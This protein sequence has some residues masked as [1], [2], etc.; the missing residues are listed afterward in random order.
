MHSPAGRHEY[1]TPEIHSLLK[2]Q[3]WMLLGLVGWLL[4]PGAAWAVDFD[5]DEPQT[6]SET[7]PTIVILPII[8]H[9]A[10]DPTHLREGF[11]DMLEA[12]VDQIG[13]FE[14]I[15]VSDPAKA[16]SRLSEALETARELDADFVLFGSFTQFGKGASLD[17]QMAA[18]DP[19]TGQ[20]PL[21]QIFVHSGS[22]GEII[23]DLDKLVGK[24][25]QYAI[26][27][28]DPEPAD[29]DIAEADDSTGV[30]ERLSE[31]GLLTQRVEALELVVSE[32]QAMLAD[33]MA[34]LEATE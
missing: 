9:S 27:D 5:E 10:A 26:E 16:T 2:R 31:I 15:N 22:I 14:I 24:L 7:L 18:T 13:R 8:V 21:R 6:P 33:R 30:E 3:S 20:E 25:G 34:Q 23:P 1:L 28:Y 19:E 32:L 4:V 29:A 12:R 11:T 17:V